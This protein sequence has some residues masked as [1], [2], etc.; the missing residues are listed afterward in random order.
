MLPARPSAPAPSLSPSRLVVP[1]AAPPA[2]GE[3][4]AADTP[5]PP[6]PGPAPASTSAGGATGPLR[7]ARAGAAG[8]R[9]TPYDRPLDTG[10]E[11]G[12]AIGSRSGIRTRTRADLKSEQ[13][14]AWADAPHD[15]RADGLPLTPSSSSSSSSSSSASASSASSSAPPSASTLRAAA[16]AALDHSTFPQA[17]WGSAAWSAARTERSAALRA[18]WSTCSP[19][20]RRQ[21]LHEA[22][23]PRTFPAPSA[24]QVAH[25]QARAV[26]LTQMSVLIGLMSRKERADQFDEATDHARALPG[27][28]C[29]PRDFRQA[30]ALCRLRLGAHHENM[31]PAEQRSAFHAA[32]DPDHLEA[33]RPRSTSLN[34]WDA[35]R[36]LR[37]EVALEHLQDD[38]RAGVLGELLDPAL[39]IESPHPG[40]AGPQASPR[41]WGLE[42]WRTVTDNLPSQARI[43]LVI[44]LLRNSTPHF[45]GALSP[46]GARAR[47]CAQIE[48]LSR[49]PNKQD[50]CAALQ[51]RI[52]LPPFAP[53]QDHWEFAAALRARVWEITYMRLDP[54][55]RAAEWQ[56]L[57]GPLTLPAPPGDTAAR[58]NAMRQRLDEIAMLVRVA[59]QLRIVAG[60]QSGDTLWN[61]AMDVASLPP[62]DSP[63]SVW[64]DAL[65]IRSEALWQLR[66]MI[67][68]GLRQ[69]A[70]AGPGEVDPSTPPSPLGGG[71]L[72]GTH[73]QILQATAARILGPAMATGEA[74]VTGP[75]GGRYGHSG[76]AVQLLS[77]SDPA[78]I[79]RSR[80][81]SDWVL[82]PD[83]GEF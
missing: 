52:T 1:G 19:A 75:L 50:L 57:L 36:K 14:S 11:P 29:K 15:H 56:R 65:A 8:H 39:V 60:Q 32:T 16:L 42:K 63:P 58:P 82:N 25:D 3:H 51:S 64:E 70:L 18:W 40:A 12:T 33:K 13:P 62:A 38:A 78:V 45:M 49:G 21:F 28:G 72:P 77:S 7:H 4:P 23:D 27:S 46:A 69:A 80:R 41:Y 79:A 44:G 26:R 9:R 66:R 61:L 24:G 73:Q 48:P 59:D 55:Q 76:R 68:P 81:G 37:I 2:G 22:L 17:A 83:D 34:S 35:I 5:A 47:R 10:S 30:V 74:R 43:E 53:G 67:S 71:H 54:D 6:A 31:T 20:Q